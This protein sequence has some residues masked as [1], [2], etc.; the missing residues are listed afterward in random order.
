[1]S[2]FKDTLRLRA[3]PTL[4][5]G[6]L[7]DKDLMHGTVITFTGAA[8]RAGGAGR[9]TRAALF[10]ASDQGVAA[11]LWLLTASP[12]NSTLTAN[13]P[14]T[15]HGT[16]LA[17]VVA[18]IPFATASY[19]D[20]AN[21]QVGQVTSIDIAYQCASTSTDLFGLLV[22]RGA[23]TYGASGITLELQVNRGE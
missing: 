23:G 2:N 9:I 18:V 4:D 10:D 20:A 19:N 15:L 14:L 3:T 12:T 1:M 22:S 21:G 7:A 17:T 5:T 11:D 13:G 8:R 16:D 6:L